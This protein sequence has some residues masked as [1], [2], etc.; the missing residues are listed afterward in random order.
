MAVCC[1]SDQ[2]IGI[3]SI[4]TPHATIGEWGDMEYSIPIGLVYASQIIGAVLAG[5]LF[6]LPSIVAFI[7]HHQNRV[8][9]CAVN[10]ILGLT[11]V[12]WVVAMI[13]ALTHVTSGS[14]HRQTST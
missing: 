7:R 8:G 11:L 9:I 2:S 12:G 5:L 4:W 3:I 1:Q 14:S 6:L 13:W 10:I